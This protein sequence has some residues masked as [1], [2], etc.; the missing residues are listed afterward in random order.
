MGKKEIENII[1][2]LRDKPFYY[3][4]D[5][6]ESDYGF[7]MN[8]NV[9]SDGI[10]NLFYV[11]R[12][13]SNRDVEVYY[14]NRLNEKQEVSFLKDDAIEY[15]KENSWVLKEFFQDNIVFNDVI[16]DIIDDTDTLSFFDSLNESND[17]LGW[18]QD[19]IDDYPF[20]HIPNFDHQRHLIRYKTKNLTKEYFKDLIKYLYEL[21]W[22]FS[23]DPSD[24]TI[25]LL[26]DYY[27]EQDC[28]I[29]LKP[30][31]FMSYGHSEDTLRISNGGLR[32]KNVDTIWI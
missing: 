6:V 23:D 25:D 16:Q 13:V 27:K 17:D 9:I 22:H 21:G 5:N 7:S 32:F 31:G 3:Y 4:N 1:D 19:I 11:G 29:H 2:Y 26:Y 15:F 12:N 18:V 20:P 10:G 14:Y 24:I 8:N 30:N 28:Y